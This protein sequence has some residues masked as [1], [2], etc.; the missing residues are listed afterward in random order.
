M[1]R[2]RN[3]D[4]VDHLRWYCE[5]CNQVLH[6]ATL[7]VEDLATQLKPII[8]TFYGDEALRTCRNCQAVLQPPAEV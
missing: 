4:E 1:E 3:A 6:D 5:G 2:R 8:E 7:H